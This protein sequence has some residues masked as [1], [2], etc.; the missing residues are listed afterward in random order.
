MIVLITWLPTSGVPLTLIEVK[1]E[2]DSI[3]EIS[4][5]NGEF[6][7]SSTRTYKQ[8][9]QVKSSKSVRWQ[10]DTPESTYIDVTE[11]L[12]DNAIGYGVIEVTFNESQ[13]GN[14]EASVIKSVRF[15]KNKGKYPKVTKNQVKALIDQ[16]KR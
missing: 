13:S 7:E 4:A 8:L 14:Y 3:F 15:S 16:S 12:N 11:W 2:E 5:A 9:V 10:F 1:G 6:W